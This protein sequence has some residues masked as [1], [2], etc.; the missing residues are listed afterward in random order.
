MA[1]SLE[2]QHTTPNSILLARRHLLLLLK[3]VMLAI[4]TFILPQLWSLLKSIIQ[5]LILELY[6]Y[7]ILL[8]LLQIY[9]RWYLQSFHIFPP[10]VA[11]TLISFENMQVNYTQYKYLY[12]PQI[13]QKCAHS[14]SLGMDTMYRTRNY[15][16]P[17]N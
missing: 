11:C 8:F 9:S 13:L 10:K 5:V 3:L 17:E 12:F 1:G 7:N 14:H 4:N 2:A 16:W 6:I 15:L